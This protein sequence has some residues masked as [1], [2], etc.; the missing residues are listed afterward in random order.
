MITGLINIS[1]GVA[2]RFAQSDKKYGG[3]VGIG[4]MEKYKIVCI[5]DSHYTAT[6]EPLQ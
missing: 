6:M 3:F 1:N 2:W 5:N 4:V